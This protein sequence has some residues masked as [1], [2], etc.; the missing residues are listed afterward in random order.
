MPVDPGIFIAFLADNPL[1]QGNDPI[2][3]RGTRQPHRT[4]GNENGLSI[5]NPS[6]WQKRIKIASTYPT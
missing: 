4:R 3:T 6:S 5:K 2:E 1:N